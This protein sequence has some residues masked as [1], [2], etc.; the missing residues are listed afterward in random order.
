MAAPPLL[1][2]YESLMISSEDL[3]DADVLQDK[4]GYARRRIQRLGFSGA[5]TVL[6][7]GCGTGRF[8]IALA[9]SNRH[10]VAFDLRESALT[11]V[12]QLSRIESRGNICPLMGTATRLPFRNATFDL[13][14]SWQCLNFVNDYVGLAEVLRVLKPGGR[15]YLNTLSWGAILQRIFHWSR[16][17]RRPELALQGIQILLNTAVLEPIF[18]KRTAPLYTVYYPGKYDR[19]LKGIDGNFKLWCGP[20]GSLSSPSGRDIEVLQENQD[21]YGGL[22]VGVEALIERLS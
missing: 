3:S 5:D 18:R 22:S 7:L 20:D 11:T 13:V 9:E 12:K 14:F 4:V 15:A 16:V 19:I 17:R 21:S 8:A 2:N 1:A 6:D 10:V